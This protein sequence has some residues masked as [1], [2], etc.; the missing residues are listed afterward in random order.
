MIEF[1]Y[2]NNRTL[3]DTLKA[4]GQC[5]DLTGTMRSFK[6]EF[7]EQIH[8]VEKHVKQAKSFR[9]KPRPAII[10]ECAEVHPAV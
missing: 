10:V 1:S 9:K 5:S 7:N 8:T 6:K 3:F 4:T 2:N